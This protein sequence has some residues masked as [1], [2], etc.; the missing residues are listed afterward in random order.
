[1]AKRIGV[2]DETVIARDKL[3]RNNLSKLRIE[4]NNLIVEKD[5]FKEG[6]SLAQKEIAK[7]KEE[8][9]ELE[10]QLEASKD[11]GKPTDLVGDTKVIGSETTGLP[12]DILAVKPNGKKRTKQS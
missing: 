12:E 6:L 7:L 3:L 5:F 1:M 2:V 8:K 11:L 4:H 10:K 9:A